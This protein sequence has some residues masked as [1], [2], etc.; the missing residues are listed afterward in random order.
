[1]NFK[2]FNQFKM[3]D[4]DPFLLQYN[5]IKM[6]LTFIIVTVRNYKMFLK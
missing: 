2:I 6:M 4:F 5:Y 1:M 3:F